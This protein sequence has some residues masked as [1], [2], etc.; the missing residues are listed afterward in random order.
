MLASG[1]RDGMT[2]HA[3]I[4]VS[5]QEATSALIDHPPATSV[6]RVW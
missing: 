4:D 3:K 6:K 2:R 5:K 1:T